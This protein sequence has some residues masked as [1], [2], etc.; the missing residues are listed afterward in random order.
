MKPE[1][2]QP[3]AGALESR[4]LTYLSAAPY[5]NV[6]LTWLIE[7]DVQAARSG[8]YAY[9][10]DENNVRGVAFFGRQVVLAAHDEETIAAFAQTAPVYRF[11]RMIVGP[12]PTVEKYWQRVRN[13][14]APAR[15]VRQSQPLLALEAGFLREGSGPV[16]VRR[17]RPDEW[18]TVADNSAAMIRQELEYDPQAS[19][20][21]FGANVRAMISRG[22]WWVGEHA[23][24]LVFFCNA[25]PHSMYTLQL[26]GIWTPPNYRGAG[27]AT[28][29][30]RGVCR[31]L[32]AYVPTVSLYVNDFNS[33]ALALYERVGFKRVG[34]FAT[35]LF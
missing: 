33:S 29:A 6:F 4:A 11:E 1:R 18:R 34:E 17:A 22:L 24:E 3:L 7:E 15:L 26:Q 2:V 30:L 14:H 16:S 23:G 19:G 8:L 12:R 21:E 20:L 27:L 10:D 5:D 9:A 13:W 28:A 31:E 25:G 35:L 32:L